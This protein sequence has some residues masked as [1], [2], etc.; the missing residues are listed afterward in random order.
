LLFAG[1]VAA[2]V[3]FWQVRRV[4]R[5]WDRAEAALKRHDLAS[6]AAYLDRYLEHRPRDTAALFLAG[7]TARRLD[8]YPEAERHLTR[9]QQLGGVTDA[10]LLEWDLL[11]VQQGDLGDLHTK[12]RMSIP[13]D[14]PD[15]L[16]VLEALAKGYLKDGRLHDVSQA[17]TLWIARQPDHPW[18]WLWRGGIYERMANYHKALADY[19]RA[20]EIAPDDRDVRLALG[21][22]FAQWRHP[23]EAAEHFE[24]LLGR[25]PD[26]REA[27][28]GLA[29]CHI[30]QGRPDE[31]VPLIERVLADKPGLARAL[32]LRGKAALEQRDRAA[33]ESWLAR[34]VEAAPDDPEALHQLTV[35]LRAR[36]KDAEAD[37]LAP[38]LEALRKDLARLSELTK[39]IAR[40]PDEAAPRHEA[41]VIA[42][43]LGRPDE[44]VRWLEG[45]LHARGD[46]RPIHA[47]LAE[48]FRGR[49][50]P[51][52]DYHR[53]QAQT[54]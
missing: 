3:W 40:K 19:S 30:E 35:A 49:D 17:C 38:R 37:R 36:N 2:G 22:L 51:R 15:A 24:H 16:I 25:S 29:A 14:H 21:T 44:G 45:A 46:H 11:R 53:R 52:A 26:D 42:L 20:L 41:G 27:L 6:A 34:A 23:A 43:R 18:P 10:T 9:C 28:C 54:P 32:F 33:A 12:L 31:A 4:Q 39:T 8:R 48:H 5:E 47:A 7:R 1:L 13:P 50:D